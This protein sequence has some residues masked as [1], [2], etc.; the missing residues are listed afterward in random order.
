MPTSF[1]SVIFC[2]QGRMFWKAGDFNIADK[3]NG[4]MM[5]LE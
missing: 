5:L 2:I 1:R 3:L 4:A